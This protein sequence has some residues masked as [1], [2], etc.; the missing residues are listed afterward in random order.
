[1]NYVGYMDPDMSLHVVIAINLTVCKGISP[2]ISRL[3]TD[4]GHEISA[5]NLML[6]I[7]PVRIF[8]DEFSMDML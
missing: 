5:L 1:M 4:S 8:S 6:Q 2:V 3:T 7:I